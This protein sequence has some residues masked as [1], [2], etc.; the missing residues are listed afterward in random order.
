MVAPDQL[1]LIPGFEMPTSSVGGFC[2][3]PTLRSFGDRQTLKT[4]GDSPPRPGGP[5]FVSQVELT[6][7]LRSQRFSLPPE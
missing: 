6:G 1:I 3:A 4:L 2:E 7:V 5:F